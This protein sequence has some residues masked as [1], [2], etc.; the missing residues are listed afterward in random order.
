MRKGF[1]IL[2][3]IRI[4]VFF[5]FLILSLSS[6]GFSQE[7]SQNLESYKKMFRQFEAGCIESGWKKQILNV[8][9]DNRKLLFKIPT[10]G[11]NSGAIIVLHGGGGDYANY[12]R[13]VKLGKPMVDFA[14]M[15]LDQ[16][17][18]VFS[19][20]SGYNLARDKN[21]NGCGKRWAGLVTLDGWEKDVAFIKEVIE[22]FILSKRPVQ[23]SNKIF[24]A[25]I[26]NG[27]FMTVLASTKLNEIV[28]G[29]VSVSSGDP[30]G[31]YMNCASDLTERK[32]APGNFLD[33]ETNKKISLDNACYSKYYL[34]EKVVPRPSENKSVPFM[35]VHDEADMGVDISCMEKSFNILKINGYS[36]WNPIVI[37]KVDRKR[38]LSHFWQQSYNQPILDFFK[39]IK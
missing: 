24:I 20:D 9:G 6:S 22:N 29:F 4:F 23:G 12:C 18:A 15:A 14:S 30:Y 5:S 8:N 34:S 11:W 35:L 21:G 25:G 1:K 3:I 16:G 7:Q 36:A 38:L 19:L 26:S 32:Y 28:D 27:G 39:S 33:L 13:N 10:N 2:N 17:F 37:K 31:T